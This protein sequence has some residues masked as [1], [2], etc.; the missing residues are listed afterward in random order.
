MKE[1]I[2]NI[3]F[4]MGKVLIGFDPEVFMG[5]CVVVE[6]K[7]EFITGA[8]VE[9]YFPRNATRILIKRQLRQFHA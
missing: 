1:N 9:E 5:P 4:D 8:F 3:I 6:V 7:E 2:R